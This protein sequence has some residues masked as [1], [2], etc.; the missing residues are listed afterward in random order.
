MFNEVTI[1]LVIDSQ[2]YDYQTTQVT[3]MKELNIYLQ[4]NI[5]KSSEEYFKNHKMSDNILSEIEKIKRPIKFSEISSFKNGDEYNQI[6]MCRYSKKFPIHLSII[7]GRKKEDSL[8][9]VLKK[10]FEEN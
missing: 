1:R 5:I 4:K 2:S 6:Q 8:Y 7:V 10:V 3:D 9:D